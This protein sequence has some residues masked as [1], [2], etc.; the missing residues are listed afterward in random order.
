[1][2]APARTLAPCGTPGAHTRH[3]RRGEPIDQV[4]RAAKNAYDN[5]R[6]VRKR[7]RRRSGADVRETAAAPARGEAPDTGLHHSQHA[8]G[9]QFRTHFRDDVNAHRL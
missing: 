9:P 1:V 8:A 4:C 5:A 7:A 3:R 6:R 2:T